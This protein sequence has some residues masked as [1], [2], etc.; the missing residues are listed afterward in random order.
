MMITNAFSFLLNGPCESS[1]KH[2]ETDVDDLIHRVQITEESPAGNKGLHE[3]TH[4][5]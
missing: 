2:N 4:D 3:E 5:I 1:F